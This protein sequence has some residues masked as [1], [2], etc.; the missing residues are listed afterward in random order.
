MSRDRCD[1]AAQPAEASRAGPV[2]RVIV[3]GKDWR[4]SEFTCHAG[5]HVRPFEERHEDVAIAAVVAGS[6][7]Y[8]TDSGRA[9]LNP[10][11]ILLGN[12]G[13]C[14]ECRHDHSTGDRC[15]SIQFSPEYFAEI[16]A[17]AAGSSRYRFP[18]AMLP[19][20][21]HVTPAIVRLE[22]MADGELP[23][24]IEEAVASLVATVLATVSGHVA[25]RGRTSARDERRVAE[26]VRYLEE[27][28]TE[29]LDLDRLAKVA[30]LSKYHFLRTFRR[31]VGVSPYQFLLGVRMRRAALRLLRSSDSIASIS[32]ESGF[33]DLS[34]FNGHFRDLFGT[35]PRDYRGRM[36]SPI[37]K[38]G[39]PRQD[40]GAA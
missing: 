19:V 5:P 32:F 14:F 2:E 29:P 6:F 17:T 13:A 36:N 26:V 21:K 23:L 9:L 18:A 34:T 33:G 30:Y 39:S 37:G 4:M 20:A 27:H 3:G 40:P 38:T 16:S 12:S 10:G 7:T 31:T 22:T 8:S 1:T 15:V 35:S 11:A 28:A 24:R 25:S